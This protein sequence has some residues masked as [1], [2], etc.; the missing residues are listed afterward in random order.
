[1][2]HFTP[3]QKLEK[4]ANKHNTKRQDKSLNLSLRCSG[5]VMVFFF[6]CYTAQ[7]QYDSFFGENSTSWITAN[8]FPTLEYGSIDSLAYAG[9]VVLNDTTYHLFDI[10]FVEATLNEGILIGDS[11]YHLNEYA[12]MR[13]SDDHS[14]LYFNYGT[15]NAPYPGE[16]IAA[17]LNLEVGDMFQS[18]TVV[19]VGVD[20]QGRKLI[21][22]SNGFETGWILEG[23]GSSGFAALFG[24][25]KLICQKKDG[26]NTFAIENSLLSNYCEGIPLSLGAEPSI[27]DILEIYPNPATNSLSINMIEPRVSSFAIYNS[28][29]VEVL[30]EQ[31]RGINA[32]I[33]ISSLAQGLY[34]F[35]LA[36]SR[37][38]LRFLKI[39]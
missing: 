6:F 34:L 11:Y 36:G 8:L 16:Q 33:D 10:F 28:M 31:L 9:D 12:W 13:E 17:D 1:M 29:G 5:T 22:L 14:K 3:S 37:G 39:E 35:Q 7:A 15:I 23:V 4:R 30:E 20:P 38:A 18:L 25:T 26:T 32:T 19:G 2:I 24:W 21:S 27:N